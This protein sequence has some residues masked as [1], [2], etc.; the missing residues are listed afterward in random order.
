MTLTAVAGPGWAFSSWTGSVV[1]ATDVNPTTVVVTW[2]NDQTRTVT[3]NFQSSDT[4]YQLDTV[5]VGGTIVLQPSQPSEGYPIN[6]TVTVAAAADYGYGFS[7]WQGDVSGTTNPASLVMDSPKS[8]VGVFNPTVSVMSDP[9]NGGDVILDP[10]QAST[11]YVAASEVS[12]E[13]IPADGYC[14][15]HWSGNLSGSENPQNIIV[16]APVTLTAH[17]LPKPPFP[18][19]WIGVGA[20]SIIPA[21]IV[22]RVLYVLATRRQV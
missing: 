4:R 3:C 1:T 22:L 5:S 20:I 2:P 19:L 8:V 7:L 6:T 17:F 10:P 11:G 13:A 14:F 21:I 12:V 15:D 18:W 9:A 16:D